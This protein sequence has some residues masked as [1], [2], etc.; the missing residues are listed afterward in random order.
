MYY[1]LYCVFIT[2]QLFTYRHKNSNGRLYSNES[3]TY[4]VF[5]VFWT[6]GLFWE[7][8]S[9]YTILTSALAYFYIPLNLPS[10]E[11]HW[12]VPRSYSIWLYINNEMKDKKKGDKNV[13]YLVLKYLVLRYCLFLDWQPGNRCL[14]KWKPTE[15]AHGNWFVWKDPS[16]L[17]KLN[18][19]TFFS[20]LSY[21]H[22]ICK[23]FETPQQG[24]RLTE[25]VSA[26]IKHSK[27][28]HTHNK[29]EHQRDV[30]PLTA[31]GSSMWRHNTE[32]STI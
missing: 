11:W 8:F 5:L 32:P 2:Q 6:F 24:W 18:T 30:H 13:L 4:D 7:W 26:L 17:L 31:D 15:P 22:L 25:R 27:R 10:W 23:R 14:R 12:D 20:I 29:S 21:F 1:S 3:L 9:I 28:W 16:E 19:V